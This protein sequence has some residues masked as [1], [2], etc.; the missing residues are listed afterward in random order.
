MSAKKASV[1]KRASVV[2]TRKKD[3]KPFIIEVMVYVPESG[4][5]VEILIEKGCT[6]ANKAIWK[7]VFDLYKKKASGDGFEQIVHVSYR[8]LNAK[9]NAA[10]AG[11]V[12][13]MN[14]AQIDELSNL[15]NASKKFAANPT[16]ANETA[17]TSAAHNVVVAK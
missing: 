6:S 12:N 9:E 15:H 5:K 11:M 4:Y 1:A 14:D 16:T 10:I 17:V 8:G 13:S 7:F 2:A 3:C